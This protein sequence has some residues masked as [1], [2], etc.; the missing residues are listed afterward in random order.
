MIAKLTVDPQSPDMAVI[1]VV[2]AS[3]TKVNIT[4]NENFSAV[5]DHHVKVDMTTT[6]QTA[7][8]TMLQQKLVIDSYTL[9]Q[10]WG[11][12]SHKAKRKVQHTT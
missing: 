4:D 7:S 10:C 5:L 11:I 6:V 2:S 12:P 8:L 1:S 3:Y 9:A